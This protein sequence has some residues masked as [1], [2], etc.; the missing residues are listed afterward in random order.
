MPIFMD[1][2]DMSGMTAED[3]AKAHKLDLEIQDQYG[4]KFVTYW[5]DDDRKTGFCLID[6]PDAETARH[7]HAV[8]HGNLP[9]DVIA[10]DMS[11]VEAFLGRVS[12]AARPVFGSVDGEGS[13]FRAVMFTDIVDS[14]A[15][16]RRLGDER[17]LEM[18]R[19][20]DAI[21]RRALKSADGNEVKHTGDGLMASFAETSKS[22]SCA[23][24]IQGALEA[25]NLASDEKLE[26]RIGLDAGEPIV[27]DHDLFGQT[28][29]L[30]A[31]LCSVAEKNSIY[32]SDVV[33]AFAPPTVT[34]LERG[35]R[36][37]KGFADPVPVFEV[38]W[39]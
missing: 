29:Q 39:N 9:E 17:S 13:A 7:V 32:V 26:V 24:A 34:V 6:A 35:T 31:R 12:N 23:Q 25:F 5:F 14:T 20:H 2:H 33:K 36:V 27:E 38:V 16:T 28:V 21:V 30:A 10:V 3:V 37:L 19:A 11:A 8:A 1:R 18:V 15:M 22:I 4:V